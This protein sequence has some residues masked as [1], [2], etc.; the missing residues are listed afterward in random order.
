MNFVFHFYPNIKK[1]RIT[2]HSVYIIQNVDSEHIR[3]FD[4][5][6]KYPRV[7]DTPNTHFCDKPDVF[8]GLHTVKG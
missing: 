5:N 1:L 8:K 3:V 2:T 6:E 7:A 4:E